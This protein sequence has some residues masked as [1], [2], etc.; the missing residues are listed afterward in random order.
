MD[1]TK[2][3]IPAAGLGTRFLPMTKSVPKELLPILNKPALQYIVE[4]GIKSGIENYCMITSRGKDAIA[5]HFDTYPLFDMMLKEFNKESLMSEINAIL[6]K[7]QFSY[8][9]QAEPLGLGHAISLARSYIG[10]EY[11]GVCLPDDII[12]SKKPGL[13]QLIALA[14]QEKASII[15]VQEV[16]MNS[17]S[18]YG[19]ISIKKQIITLSKNR[20][21]KMRLQILL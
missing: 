3:V 4:E 11:F 13:G 5:D 19:V 21:K 1:I 2:V 14:H 8:I 6:R 20:Y 9:R 18:A 15:A 7:A 17:I 16:P 12:F 10:K